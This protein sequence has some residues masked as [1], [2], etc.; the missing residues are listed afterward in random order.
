MDAWITGFLTALLSG[1]VVGILMALFKNKID[2]T[3]KRV[4]RANEL[5]LKNLENRI[6][7]LRKEFYSMTVKQDKIGDGV[8]A[9]NMKVSNMQV[10]LKY[11]QDRLTET[12]QLVK[13]IAENQG[14]GKV[15]RK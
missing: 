2:L 13:V 9:I 8:I 14:F 7:E 10:E 3:A 15:I 4:E 11:V 6:E 12:S 5:E 1:C